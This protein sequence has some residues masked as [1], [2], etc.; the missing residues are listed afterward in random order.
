MFRASVRSRIWY[1]SF[2]G[3]AG[4]QREGPGISFEKMGHDTSEITKNYTITF[5]IQL[6]FLFLPRKVDNGE[7]IQVKDVFVYIDVSVLPSGSL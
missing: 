4:H 1:S 6:Q 2:P 7:H 5:F 3:R